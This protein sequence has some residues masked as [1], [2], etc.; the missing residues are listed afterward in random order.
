MPLTLTSPMTDEARM[1]ILAG[2]VGRADA[3]VIITSGVELH[4]VIFLRTRASSRNPWVVAVESY[5]HR[6][7]WVGNPSRPVPRICLWAAYLVDP[8]L[9]HEAAPG[10]ELLHLSPGTRQEYDTDVHRVHR[11]ARWELRIYPHE[12]P[13]R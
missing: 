3:T 6:V 11:R 4:R 13:A 10:R 12:Q 7:I 8:K 5:P 9:V 1:G 2:V